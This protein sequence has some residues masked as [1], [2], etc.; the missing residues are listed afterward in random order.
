MNSLLHVINEL[1]VAFDKCSTYND[2]RNKFLNVSSL[3]NSYFNSDNFKNKNLV[4]P[5]KSHFDFGNS[6]FLTIKKL[7]SSDEKIS[8]FVNE[9]KQIK[10]FWNDIIYDYTFITKGPNI[11]YNFYCYLKK[12]KNYIE[13]LLEYS[14]QYYI[15]GNE[16]SYII[17]KRIHILYCVF[18]S[19]ENVLTKMNDNLYMYIEDDLEKFWKIFYNLKPTNCGETVYYLDLL[20]KSIKSNY[21]EFCKKYKKIYDYYEPKT[22]EDDLFF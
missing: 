3:F 21:K 14:K 9:S 16:E 18:Y 15:L 19:S 10:K 7:D 12:F 6:I 22:N 5:L 2:F 8:F 20:N 4:F 11:F 17:I 13:S 1:E